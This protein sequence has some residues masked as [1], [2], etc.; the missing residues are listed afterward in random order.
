MLFLR[1]DGVILVVNKALR[2]L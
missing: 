2:S 1:G